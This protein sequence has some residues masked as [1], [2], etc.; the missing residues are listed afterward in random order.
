MNSGSSAIRRPWICREVDA[1]L[2]AELARQ[3][4]TPE[5]VARLLVDRGLTT[6]E[7]ARNFLDPKWNG[8]HDPSELPDLEEA[9]DTILAVRDAG[10]TVGVFGD[11]DVDGISGSAIL[12]EVFRHLGIQVTCRLPHRVREGY[13]LSKIAVEEFAEKEVDLIVTVDGGSNDTEAIQLAQEL[14]LE[15]IVTDHHQVMN[16]S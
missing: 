13:G 2:S 1:S 3:L 10:G 11:Y 4:G 8:L 6:M 7:E 15:V 14:G 12:Q 9:V 16:P 5:V